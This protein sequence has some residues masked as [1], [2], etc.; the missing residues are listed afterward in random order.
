MK[1][2]ISSLFGTSKKTSRPAAPHHNQS[3]PQIE[4]LEGR[5][6]LSA[7]PIAAPIAKPI[8]STPAMTQS[9]SQPVSA[10]PT[11][12]TAAAKGTAADPQKALTHFAYTCWYTAWADYNYLR[13]RR[14][15]AAIVMI[16]KQLQ[17]VESRM[18]DYERAE[19]YLEA[20]GY[21]GAAFHFYADHF[22][23]DYHMAV[24]WASYWWR[25]NATYGH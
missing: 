17:Q 25:Y 2:F 15:N 16:L 18:E 9:I 12:H 14:S 22:H 3:R 21:D 5:E 7:S 11:S 19:P 24:A 23:H 10:Q 8:S 1:R 13:Q 6:M 20:Y 4:G